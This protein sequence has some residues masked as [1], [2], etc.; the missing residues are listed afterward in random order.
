MRSCPAL[1][2][3]MIVFFGI[4]MLPLFATQPF[5]TMDPS[6]RSID[7]A[8]SLTGFDVIKYEVDLAI[9]DQTHFINGSVKA[10]VM[11]ESF[12]SSITYELT[13]GTLTVSQVKV[14]DQVSPF[15]HQNGLISIPLSFSQGTS[16][17][18]EVFYSGVPGNSPAPYNIGLLFTTNGCYTLS[19]PDAGRY[20]WP[21]YDHPWDKALI[22][23]RITVRSDWIAVANG[24][25][26]AVINNGNGTTQYCWSHAHPVATYVMGFA[27][28]PYVVFDQTTSLPIKHYVLPGQLSNAQTDFANVPGMIQYFSDLFGAYPFEKYGHMVVSM[29]TYAAM[30]HQT[31]TTFGAQY[32]TG[33]QNY[34][35]IVAHELAHQWYGNYVTPITMR[36]VWLKESFATYSEFLWES[37]HHGWQAGCDYLGSDI[38]QYYISWENSNGPHTIFNPE[39]NLM[40]APPT[41][42]KSASVLHMLRLKMGNTAFFSFIRQ[43]LTTYAE[44]NINTAEFVALAEQV[45]G[46]DLDR[47]FQQW[48]YSPGIPDAGFSVFHNGSG[49]GKIVARSTSPTPT[50][51]YLDVPIL[52]PGSAT[53]DSLVIV[54]SPEGTTNYFQYNPVNDF[55]ALQI[56]PNHWVLRRSFTNEQLRLDACLPYQGAVDISWS[57]YP[58]SVQIS[59]Y[60][61][62]RRS[63]PSGS[64]I[65]LTD[66][67]LSDRIF[68]DS[69]VIN[70]VT[71]EYYIV[72]VDSDGFVSLPSNHLQA[73]PISFPFDQG[74]LVVD[75]TRNGSG[76]AIS[77]D[78]AMVDAF[79]QNVTPNVAH[80]VWDYDTQGAPSLSYL[81]HFPLI[82]WHSDDFSNMYLQDN[83]G[84][85]GS[86]VLSGGKL[87]I[88]GWKHPSTFT[89]A[90]KNRF[91]PGVTMD[92]HNSAVFISAQSAHYPALHPDPTKLVASWNGMLPMSYT[93]AGDFDTLYTAELSGGGAGNGDAAAIRIDDNGSL[94]ILGFPLYF[95]QSDE[96]RG[97]L[98]GIMEELYPPLSSE[99]EYLP[100]PEPRLSI[101]PNPCS[102]IQGL[103][104]SLRN[105]RPLGYSIFNLRGQE[106]YHTI[107]RQCPEKDGEY[108]FSPNQDLSELP[109]GCYIIRVTTDRGILSAKLMLIRDP[110]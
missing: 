106:L 101:Y 83:L 9:N 39:Y 64:F 71:Y 81:S 25:Q 62:Y 33:D 41:Y 80:E 13:G 79:Y 3:L 37:Y 52:I 35:S 72:A 95:M 104:I 99:D 43:I 56:D 97:F 22:D 40:F 107:I 87:I 76:S 100:A 18:T 15:T 34:E 108:R 94:V 31:T 69:Q 105:S 61:I 1:I 17:T 27:A 98:S 90:F 48:I 12:L 24:I 44:G 110:H 75:E 8:D 29:S 109:T 21:S 89:P 47:F 57:A 46:L 2:A 19:N 58:G 96:V 4:C 51:F 102:A 65:R 50:Q 93:F 36:E 14:N 85:L 73:T 103:H 45:S 59:G 63:L 60:H 28:A 70:G 20:F 42:E 92:L 68:T 74:L 26:G 54:A 23:W 11:A 77:P 88:S 30:E 78:D 82:L 84:N 5:W 53:P 16:F 38:Q 6:T 55:N 86:Y 32:L 66:D 49:M 91:L 10:H 7:R 67:P